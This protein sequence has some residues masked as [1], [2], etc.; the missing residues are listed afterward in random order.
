MTFTLLSL[1][2]LLDFLPKAG[3]QDLFPYLA[4]DSF[5]RL[6]TKVHL[7]R[8]HDPAIKI[9]YFDYPNTQS[10]FPNT[11][12]LIRTQT[13]PFSLLKSTCTKLSASVFVRFRFSDFASLPWSIKDLFEFGLCLE[14]GVWVLPVPGPGS[15]GEHYALF[16]CLRVEG[17]ISLASRLLY[18]T[19]GGQ[20]KMTSRQR[21][22]GT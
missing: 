3:P 14:T 20:S 8:Y 9:H 2:K 15:R 6:V 5:R 10:E 11:P 12:W 4:A 18:I 22:E 13:S 17:K 7:S 21:Y 1:A 16:R 19:E